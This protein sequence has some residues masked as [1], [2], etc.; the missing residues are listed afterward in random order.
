MN[1][2]RRILI[3]EDEPAIADTL[4]YALK[5]EGFAPEWCTTGG[6]ALAALVTGGFALVVLDVGLPDGSGFDVC[7]AIRA[8]LSVPIIFLTARNTEFDRVLGLELGGDDYLAKP[9]S[10]RELTA[11]VKAILR[12]TAGAGS[13]STPE[14]SQSLV[15]K[16]RE[17]VGGLAGGEMTGGG[18]AGSGGMAGGDG[19]GGFAVDEARCAIVFRAV[20]L[21]LTRYEFRLLKTLVAQP[22]RVF[23]RDQLMAAA[24]EDPGASLDR[25][26]DAHIKTLRTKLRAVAPTADPIQTHRGLG[27]SLRAES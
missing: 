23:S 25:T 24:W 27:Y 21:E 20:K 5:T 11:R 2:A 12:R 1:G 18:L 13:S 8:R 4:I 17:G 9:F 3:V 6:A 15:D 16:H 7:K 14:V 22:G 26:V 19:R 10:P